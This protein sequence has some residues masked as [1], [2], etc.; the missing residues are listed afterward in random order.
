[1]SK[2]EAGKMDISSELIEL[3]PI[4]DEVKSMMIELAKEKKVHLSFQIDANFGNIEADPARFKQILI[5]LISNAIKFNREDGSVRVQL[6]KSEDQQWLIGQVEDTG[7]GI[8][9]TKVPELFRKFYQVD[10][11]FARRHEGTGLGLALTKELIELHGGEI[12]VDS[13]EGKGSIFT[14]KMPITLHKHNP[15]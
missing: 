10:T 12:T 5:N 11:S 7:I 2:V 14:F 9:E 13:Q 3:N 4:V 1:M 15:L 8:S 6:T